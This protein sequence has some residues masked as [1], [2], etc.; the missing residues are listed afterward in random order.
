MTEQVYPHIYRV[1]IPLPGNPL[2]AI[3]VHLIRGDGRNLIID[4][5][6]SLQEGK[7][8]ILQ[9]LSELK[10]SLAE[11]ELLIT[12]LHSDHCGLAADFAAGGMTVWAGAVDGALINAMATEAYWERFISLNILMG[13][14]EDHITYQEHPGYKY[15]PKEPVAFRLLREGDVL[16]LGKFRFSVLDVPG[17]T[18]GHI[19]LYEPDKRLLFS[20]DHI[21]DRITPNIAFWGFEQDILAVYLQSLEKVRRLPVE[22]CF[23]AHRNLLTDPVRRIDELKTH[24]VKRLT[25]ILCIL[26]EGPRTVRQT[27]AAMHWDLRI[28]DWES[29]PANQKW[30]AAG[31]A[32]SHLEHLRATGRAER[33][34]TEGVLLYQVR[35]R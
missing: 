4:T 25:E 14:S 35:Q 24:H 1:E 28:S 30:F 2:K 16:D 5:G 32:L 9:A 23:P 13:L 11:T 3:H 29:F 6:F 26:S 10:M 34:E 20:G 21:L 8:A 12:H 19:A 22:L 27:A 31:E 15:C 33:T 7:T 17:H 18:P